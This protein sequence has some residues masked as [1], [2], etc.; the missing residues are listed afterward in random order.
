M[1]FIT[2][3]RARPDR[4][5]DAIKRRVESLPSH[6]QFIEQCCAAR[7]AITAASAA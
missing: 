1:F 2:Q 7:S 4:I 3:W 6:G 5:R